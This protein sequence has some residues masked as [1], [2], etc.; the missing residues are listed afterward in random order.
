MPNDMVKDTKELRALLLEILPDMGPQTGLNTLSTNK[1]IMTKIEEVVHQYFPT[2]AP[3]YKIDGEMSLQ[4]LVAIA[5]GRDSINKHSIVLDKVLEQNHIRKDEQTG[6]YYDQ[7]GQEIVTKGPA[8]PAKRF[9]EFSPE[10]HALLAEIAAEAGLKGKSDQEIM[11]H[12]EQTVPLMFPQAAKDY[13][14]DGKLDSR[15]LISIAAGRNA[16]GIGSPELDALLRKEGI[17]QIDGVLTDGKDVQQGDQQRG[18]G[19]A[20]AKEASGV[21]PR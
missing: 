10:A 13:T 18:S 5:K 7:K 14:P 17:V 6:R 8:T 12:L 15:E 16:V 11:Q 2:A 20:K 1:E 3:D 9:I 19:G 4:E 21:G